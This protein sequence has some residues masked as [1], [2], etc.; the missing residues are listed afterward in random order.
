MRSEHHIIHSQKNGTSCVTNMDYMYWAGNIET[1]GMGYKK[2]SL[3]HVPEWLDA[4]IFRSKNM[5]ERDET[6][7]L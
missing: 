4:H 6:N 3:A 5:F 1:H 2:K 7:H